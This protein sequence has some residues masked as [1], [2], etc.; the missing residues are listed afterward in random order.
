[1]AF[2]LQA[3]YIDWA[4]TTGQQNLVTT[5]AA[6]GMWPGQCCRSPTVINLSF[7]DWKKKSV[8]QSMLFQLN[9]EAQIWLIALNV[10]HL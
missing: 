4:A 7:L 10:P 3:N 1:M 8:S 6:R 9:T 5:L 2:R